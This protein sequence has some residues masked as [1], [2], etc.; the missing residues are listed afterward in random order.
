MKKIFFI[1]SISFLFLSCSSTE[2]NNSSSNLDPL[3]GRWWFR[4][5]NYNNDC[6]VKPGSGTHTNSSERYFIAKE[7][8]IYAFT[9][10]DVSDA[11]IDQTGV[12][13]KVT[14]PDE[15]G[16][17]IYN[18][19]SNYGNN[20]DVMIKFYDNNRKILNNISLCNWNEYH[21]VE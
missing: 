15:E 2:D 7:N 21:K 12:W 9:S 17:A 20:N 11:A 1:L 16:Y 6:D 18:F 19:K 4:F 13:T 14:D 5:S 10:G 3:I 8:G